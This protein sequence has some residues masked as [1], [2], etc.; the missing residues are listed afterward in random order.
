M[1]QDIGDTHVSAGANTES[2]RDICLRIEV[3]DKCA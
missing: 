2:G 1:S 3:H